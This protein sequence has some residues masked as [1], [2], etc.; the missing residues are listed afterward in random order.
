MI[1][2]LPEGRWGDE[3]NEGD[4]VYVGGVQ[5]PVQEIQEVTVALT[6]QSVWENR[7]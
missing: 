3:S 2:K 4:R 5:F 1:S 7:L 6:R